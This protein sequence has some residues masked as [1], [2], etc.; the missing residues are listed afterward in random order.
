MG[1]G[2]IISTGISIAALLIAGYLVMSGMLFTINVA[3]ASTAMVRDLKADQMA[4]GLALA[5]VTSVDAVTIEYNVTNTGRTTID[6]IT[7]MDMILKYVDQS[8]GQSLAGMWLEP[9]LGGEPVTGFGQWSGTV[10]NS[11]MRDTTGT[12]MLLPGETMTVRVVLSAPQPSDTGVVA[13]AAPDGVC[14]AKPFNFRI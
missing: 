3:T 6:N 10:L 12:L 13:A 4:T 5:N 14:A 7:R 8:S 1:F 11:P 2:S 9:A